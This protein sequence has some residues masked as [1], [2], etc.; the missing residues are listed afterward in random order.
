MVAEIDLLAMAS[1]KSPPIW[2]DEKSYDQW[3]TEIEA[4]QVVTE[5]TA[6]KRAPAVALSLDGQKREVALSIPLEEL[7]ETTGMTILMQKL[8]EVFDVH[9]LDKS[10]ADYVK[11]EAFKRND[12]IGVPEYIIEFNKLYSRLKSHT[13]ELP[14][15]ILAC[16]LLFGASLSAQETQMVLTATSEFKLNL[17]QST[18]RRIFSS[19]GPKSASASIPDQN[20]PKEEPV[21]VAEGED[22]AFMAGRHS[23]RGTT[24]KRGYSRVQTRG[25]GRNPLDKHGNVSTCAVCGSRNHWARFCPD[26]DDR[27]PHKSQKKDSNSEDDK[28]FFPWPT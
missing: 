19:S 10:F 14:D 20:L 25:R 7:K 5:L 16:K 1:Y 22:S 23:S 2:S 4:W 8:Q 26:R 12:N 21:F 17:M 3:K 6:A 15:N 27:P 9:S 24:F 11:F 28:A 13:L 18:L